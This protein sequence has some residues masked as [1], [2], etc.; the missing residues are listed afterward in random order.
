[1]P[2]Y[3]GWNIIGAGM[4]FQAM[5]FGLTF[6]TFGVWVLPWSEEFGTSRGEIMIG[7][8]LVNI[9]MGLLAPFVGHAMD[10]KPIRALV[11]AGIVMIAGGFLLVSFGTSILQVLAIYATLVAAGAILAGPLGAS[12]LA[13]KWFRARRSFA[14]GI[15]AMGTSLGGFLLP[16]FAAFLLANFGWRGAHQIIAALAIILIVPLV[17]WV[18][19]NTPEDRGIEPEPEATDHDGKPANGA[20]DRLS[21]TTRTILR[22]P[23]FWIT[24]IAFGTLTMAFS[25]VLPNLVAIAHDIGIDA[26]KAALL[27]SIL[28][29]AGMVG[30]AS[31]GYAA[32]NIDIRRLFWCASALL[33]SALFMFLTTSS[34][35]GLVLASIFMGLSSGG[36]IP[37]QGTIVGSRFGPAAFGRVM[38]LLAP[39]TLPLAIVGPPLAGFIYD[40]TGNYDLAFEIF[41][42]AVIVAGTIIFFLQPLPSLAALQTGQANAEIS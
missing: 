25:G 34:F 6:Y 41:L 2:W 22:E 38:G 9:A 33:A 30:K 28:A 27:M 16:P 24:A 19:S 14:F 1:M 37:L 10:S 26:Q 3:Y 7:Y 32:D 42:G 36:F 4:A 11:T 35:S 31:F 20:A 40:A 13:V 5:A 29:G 17:W 23:N 39:F 21:W 18:V 12:T 8:I 15:S